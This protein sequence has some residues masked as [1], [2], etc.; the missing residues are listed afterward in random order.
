MNRKRLIL[1]ALLGIL[2][3]CLLYAFYA[4]PRQQKAPPRAVVKAASKVKVTK[5]PVAESGEGRVHLDLLNS[6]P[7][8]FPG[9]ERDIFRFKQ[10]RLPP[11]PVTIA[12]PP[13]L[14][15]PELVAPVVLLPPTPIEVMQRALGQF[16]FL[17]F[18]EKSGEKTVFLSSGGELYIVKRGES[19]GAEN[20]FEVAEIDGNLLKVR[21]AGQDALVE[22][23]LIE[24][25]KL[26]AT[27]SAPVQSQAKPVQSQVS[28]A[29]PNTRRP[30]TFVPT[31]RMIRPVPPQELEVKA[32][33]TNEED[34]PAED[35]E[36]DSPET[37]DDL[38]GDVDGSNQ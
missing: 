38:K 36:L 33:E 7:E 28:P 18:L 24:Q 29:T 8:P 1:A 37:G 15:E 22:I 6:E 26:S 35:Q 12:P 25:Q 32:N 34:N 30:R 10:R 2:A 13:V 11:P 3:L 23:P 17:G 20:E 4:T 31:R 21:Q 27:I 14:P 16:T 19:F 9:A 5:Q